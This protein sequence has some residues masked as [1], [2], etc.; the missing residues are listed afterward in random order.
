MSDDLLDAMPDGTSRAATGP[1]KLVGVDDRGYRV[2]QDN[3]NAKLTDHEVDLI[4]E[5]HEGGGL[6]MREIAEKFEV[7]KST[8]VGIVN[9]NRRASYPTGWRRVGLTAGAAAI[10]AK[11]VK[12]PR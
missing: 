9:F 10:C 5:L 12:P 6:S 7:A 8:I 1:T 11:H 3:P 2:G 4:R